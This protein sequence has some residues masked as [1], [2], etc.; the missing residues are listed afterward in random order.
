MQKDKISWKRIVN[1]ASLQGSTRGVYIIEDA[2]PVLK[3][4]FNV[5]IRYMN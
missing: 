5:S 1:K 3:R 2:E 4:E